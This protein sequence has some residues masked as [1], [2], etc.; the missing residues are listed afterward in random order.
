M[1]KEYKIIPYKQI[2]T[3]SFGTHRE[4]IIN[5]IG[6]PLSSTKYG[7]PVSNR[8]LDEYEFFSMMYSN[9]L[10]LEAVEFCPDYTDNVITFLYGNKKVKIHGTIKEIINNFKIITNDMI[11]DE[12]E[13]EYSSNKLGINIFCPD[14]HIENILFYDLHYY[15]EENNYLKENNIL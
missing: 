13:E 9:K 2:G 4:D 6:K 1:K 14:N 8:L 7:F 10:E 3:Y 11:W 15:D 12:N 5:I